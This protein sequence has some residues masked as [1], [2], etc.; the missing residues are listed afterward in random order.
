MTMTAKDY[1]ETIYKIAGV[2]EDESDDDDFGDIIDFQAEYERGQKI[3]EAMKQFGP[4]PA[5][6][7]TKSQYN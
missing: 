2:F 6:I 4:P 5:Y 7:V 3:I 1:W